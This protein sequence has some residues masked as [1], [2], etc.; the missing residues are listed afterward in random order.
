M[1][2]YGIVTKN[3]PIVSNFRHKQVK[4]KQFLIKIAKLL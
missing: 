2:T 4:K 3:D 1:P